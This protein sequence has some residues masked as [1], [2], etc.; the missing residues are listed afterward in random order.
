VAP[1][2]LHV[3]AN[4]AGAKDATTADAAGADELTTTALHFGQGAL[5]RMQGPG[6]LPA[7]LAEQ[8][9]QIQAINLKGGMSFGGS[10]VWFVCCFVCCVHHNELFYVTKCYGGTP[11]INTPGTHD[12]LGIAKVSCGQVVE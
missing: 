11:Y 4:F 10:F 5:H 1:T 9:L 7:F 2:G 3:G 6:S 12:I 8:S